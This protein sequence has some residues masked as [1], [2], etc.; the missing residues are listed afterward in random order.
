MC[1][2]GHFG[3]RQSTIV[4]MR[5]LVVVPAVGVSGDFFVKLR[6]NLKGS[7]VDQLS[8]QGVAISLYRRIVIRTARFAH[9]L[10]HA[11]CLA[12]FN[13]LFGCELAALIGM[14]A[15]PGFAS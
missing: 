1:R 14:K 11:V 13:E 3:W 7:Q 4:R 6:L 12:E 8:L 15:Y 10:L 5:P 9:A 2:L